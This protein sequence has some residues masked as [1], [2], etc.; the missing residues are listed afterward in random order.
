M[1]NCPPRHITTYPNSFGM[2]MGIGCVD[3]Y[4]L[5]EICDGAGGHDRNPARGH[6]YETS[7]TLAPWPPVSRGS[8]M[9]LASGFQAPSYL[10]QSMY[11]F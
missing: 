5:M 8:I 7:N 10:S 11:S 4:Q 9:A 2:V 6:P 1:K 3:E